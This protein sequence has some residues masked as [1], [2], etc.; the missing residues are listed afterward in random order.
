MFANSDKLLDFVSAKK[1]KS[2]Y[3]ASENGARHLSCV[4]PAVADALGIPTKTR[5]YGNS[6]F[7]RETLKIP[8]ADSAVAVVADGLGFW[9]IMQKKGHF[10]YL[11]ALISEEI[12]SKPIMTCL[13]STTTAAMSVFGT[14]TC[15]S[16]TGMYGYTQL[17]PAN[18]KISQMIKFR[19]AP[20]PSELQREPTIFEQLAKQGIRATSVGLKKFDSSALTAAAFRGAQYKGSNDF[21]AQ[22]ELTAQAAKTPGLTY[23]YMPEADKT[24]HSHG[25][26]SEKWIAAAENIDARLASLRRMLPKGTLIVIT[27]DHGM[28]S[29]NPDSRIDIAQHEQLTRGVKLVGGEPRAVM[30]YCEEGENAECVADRW[31]NFLEDKARILTK[32]QALEMRLYGPAEE[33]TEPYVGDVIAFAASDVT[34]VDS[35]IQTDIATR[36]PSVHG[37][38]TI[39]ETQIPLLIDIA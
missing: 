36:L 16:M 17:N 1:F 25:W 4:L 8:E 33:R 13:P 29:S 11:R 10:K 6:K 21:N 20:A 5:L 14:G 26:E 28:I 38:A 32:K 9:N 15:P 7:L 24:G 35:R 3:A 23:L 2:A 30:L 18:G 34:L 19:D 12:N 31:R 39:A 37:S 22:I 27:A